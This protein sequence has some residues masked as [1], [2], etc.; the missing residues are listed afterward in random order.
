MQPTATPDSLIVVNNRIVS[1]QSRIP[2]LLRSIE[3]IKGDW[4]LT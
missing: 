1:I 2:A 3:E 4:G